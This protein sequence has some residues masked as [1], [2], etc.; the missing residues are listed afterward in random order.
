MKL[1]FLCE[2]PVR[3]YMEDLPG[4]GMHT[5]YVSSVPEQVMGRTMYPFM[6]NAAY[7][8]ED[9]KVWTYGEVHSAMQTAS[10]QE[11]PE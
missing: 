11:K 7:V 6:E 5:R 2:I 9:G 3:L 8:D 10:K 4:G 1:K